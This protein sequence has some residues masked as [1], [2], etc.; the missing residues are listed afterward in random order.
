M[1]AMASGCCIV[2]S[3]TPPVEEVITS[4]EQGQLVDFFD[5]EALSQ[6]VDHLLQNLEQ[7]Q[8]LGQCAN[9]QILEGG[10]DLPNT[11]KQQLQ[12]LDQVIRG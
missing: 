9:Q 11:L 12:L 8:K 5:P 4:G 3:S 7:R 6:Q 2:A 1:E 10:Y